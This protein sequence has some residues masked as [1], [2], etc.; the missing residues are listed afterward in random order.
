MT[1]GLHSAVVYRRSHGR[2]EN[3]EL[4]SRA[5]QDCI[6]GRK[7]FVA[8]CVALALFSAVHMIPMFINLVSEPTKPLEVEAK[9]A[10]AAVPVDIGP[11]HT[12][13][14]QLNQLLSTS[15]SALLYF[16][17]AVNCVA[18]RPVA[19]AGRLRS[20]AFVNA[21]FSALLLAITLVFRFPPPGVFA[22]VATVLF[23]LSAARARGT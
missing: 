14:V 5:S 10:M 15:Y 3:S 13:W 20:L 8:G 4:E 11:F 22:L 1:S 6:Q 19:A 17:V 18:L 2:T 21:A 9:R 16:V 7:L 23:G 12:S